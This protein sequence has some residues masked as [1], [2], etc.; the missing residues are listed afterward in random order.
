MRDCST[1]YPVCWGAA[2]HTLSHRA[3]VRATDDK[4]F[5]PAILGQEMIADIL[6]CKIATRAFP[7]SGLV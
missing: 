7:A 6:H 1:R 4:V 2:G 5:M 3:T